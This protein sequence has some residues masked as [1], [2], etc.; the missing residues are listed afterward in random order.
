MPS[1]SRTPEALDALSGPIQAFR[2]TLANTS[3]Q[4]RLMISTRIEQSHES[5]DFERAELGEFA[6]GRID[7][8]RLSKILARDEPLPAAD[9]GIIHEALVTC[10]ELLARNENL[11]R[12]IV[13]EGDDLRSAV[14]RG[15]AEI[16]RAYGA[17]RVVE[18]VSQGAFRAAE[19][20]SLLKGHS[21]E[22]WSR[23]ERSIEFGLVVRVCGRD[24]RAGGLA[25]YL[26]RSIKLVLVVQGD[27]PPAALVRLITPQTLVLQTSEA[28]ELEWLASYRGPG[29]AALVSSAAAQFRHD[30]AGGPALADRIVITSLPERPPKALGAASAFQQRQDLLQL[31]AL[32]ESHADVVPI[33]PVAVGEEPPPAAARA[34]P[35]ADS[36][37]A[38]SNWL[39]RQ[40]DLP[41]SS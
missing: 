31:E 15:L 22:S 14:G 18:L 36:A 16:G 7:A 6:A 28:S 41:N 32:A 11:F 24:L 29:V 34:V 25:D 9:T 38:L 4:I 27:A 19:H 35:A 30:P 26:D 33:D 21:F 40:A 8:K 37:D 10:N 20:S 39:L 2:S 1:D 13:E 12:V 5:A 17:A 23:T 3:E